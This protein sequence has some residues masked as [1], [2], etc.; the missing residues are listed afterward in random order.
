MIMTGIILDDLNTVCTGNV[1]YLS[2]A[3]CDQLLMV[4]EKAHGANA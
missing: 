2:E 3:Y 1:T 4:L